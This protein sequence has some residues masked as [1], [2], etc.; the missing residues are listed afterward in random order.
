MTAN[1]GFGFSSP[2]C[3]LFFIV[4]ML[5]ALLRCFFSVVVG[6][7][8]FFF[9]FLFA[10]AFLLYYILGNPPRAEE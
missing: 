1:G 2:L 7:F 8:T 4:K 3:L 9:S 5:T 6:T 10:V